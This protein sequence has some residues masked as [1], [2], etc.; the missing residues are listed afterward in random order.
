MR[1]ESFRS[2]TPSSS[3]PAVPI[4]PLLVVN[5]TLGILATAMKWKADDDNKGAGRRTWPLEEIDG[6]DMVPPIFIKYVESIK[7]NEKTI[8]IYRRALTRFFNMFYVQSRCFHVNTEHGLYN[9][10]KSDLWAD[11]QNMDVLAD[12]NSWTRNIVQA[13]LHLAQCSKLNY[14]RIDEDKGYKAIDQIILGVLKPWSVRLSKKHHQANTAKGQRDALII[15]EYPKPDAMKEMA[16]EAL[17]DLVVIH[18]G[19]MI[20]KT[21]K[22]NDDVR[23]VVNFITAGLSYILTPPSRSREWEGMLARDV[24]KLIETRSTLI[25]YSNYKTF[26]VYGEAGKWICETLRLAYELILQLPKT[27]ETL[28]ETRP[29]KNTDSII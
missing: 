24:Q 14:A 17:C 7:L 20:G 21:N 22:Y 10:F 23:S 4:M 2:P 9:V 12:S 28:F 27:S 3:M 11:L 13:L 6:E 29:G 1:R 15:E 25:E 8:T 5:Q 18:N 19:V 16:V 26:H